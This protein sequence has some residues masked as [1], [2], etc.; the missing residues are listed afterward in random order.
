MDKPIRILEIDP[1]LRPY[2]GDLRQRMGHYAWLKSQLL[3][4]GETLSDFANGHKYFGFHRT[5]TGWVYRE[6]APAAE[7]LSLIGDFNDWDPEATPLTKKEGGVWEV[8][9]KGEDILKHGDKVKVHVKSMGIERDRIPLYIHRVVQNKVDHSF[10]GYI[11]EPEPYVW[12]DQDYKTDFE[13]PIIYEAHVGMATEEERIGTYREF[14]DNM[15]P[16]IKAQGYNMVQLMAIMQHPY[17]GSFG[18][19]VANFFAV[20]SWFGTPEDFKYLVDKAHSLGIG[21]LMDI[22]QSHAV[23]NTAEGINEFDGTDYQFFHG[24][25]R[26]NHR[27]WD[28]KCFNYGKHEVIH[29]LLSSVKYWLEEFHLDGFRFDG[30]TSML[31]H[32]HALGTAFDS[33]DKYFSMNT[34]TDAVAYL[35]L[36]SEMANEI[37]PDVVLIAED[38][39]GMPGMCIPIEDGGIGFDFRLA[40]GM[41]DYWIRTLKKN[42]HDWNM[43]EMWHELT[44]HRPQ[45]KRVAYA[46]SHDQALVGDKTLMFR[47]ADAEMYWH[48]NRESESMVIDRAIA[49]HKMI[50]WITISLGSE[51]YLNF[52]GNEFG[53]PEWIDFPREGNGWSFKHCRRQW[54]LAE[55]DYLR[56]ID[57]NTFDIAMVHFAVKDG[58]MSEGTPQMLWID[59]GRKLLAFKRKEYVYVFNFHPTD[60]YAS[61]QLP[62]HHRGKYQVIMDTDEKRFGGYDRIAH[63]VIYETRELEDYEDRYDGIEIYVP[64][65]TALVLAPVE[66]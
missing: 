14:A 30:V 16:R 29:F 52:M 13:N 7:S 15:L 34:D 64:S 55:A 26:G 9:L 3:Q 11:W 40:M 22:V 42:D 8:E 49:L 47:M 66:D 10:D 2:E 44:T 6:W 50:R 60:S 17:Y 65:R 58:Q 20:S 5:E 4:P 21:V 39:S 51:G 35:Q 38:M 24:G 1:M 53:H 28:S 18:Y 36:V 62:T 63:D 27:E 54:N 45:E 48:M 37:N 43:F 56:Y 33:Y 59:Q 32:D 57:L 25:D 41:P 31:Y 12:N 46:E 23:K 19:H 61:F